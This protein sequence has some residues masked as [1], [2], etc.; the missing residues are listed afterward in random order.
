M[1]VSAVGAKHVELITS[2]PYTVDSG[3]SGVLSFFSC[4]KG[5][6]GFGSL[7]DAYNIQ[8]QKRK[9]MN[10]DARAYSNS[11]EANHESRSLP[12]V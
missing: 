4:F 6:H 7:H 11:Q 2:T 8:E 3:K 1:R 5:N 9:S 10:V 12:S